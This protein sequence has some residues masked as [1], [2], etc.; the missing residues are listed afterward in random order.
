MTADEFWHG[1]F[2]LTEVYREAEKTRRDN[3]AIEQWENG[4][5]IM[6]AMLTVS[7]A[8]KDFGKGVHHDYPREPLFMGH[9]ETKEEIAMTNAK[10][11][12]E[13]FAMSFNQA[14]RAKQEKGE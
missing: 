1:E 6:E 2:R 10:I 7:P 4:V 5:Y 9:R 12:F 11:E 3:K 8:F 13:A 14:F